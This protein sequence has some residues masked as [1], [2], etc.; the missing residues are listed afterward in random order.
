MM[1]D[2]SRALDDVA[3]WALETSEINYLTTEPDDVILSLALLRRVIGRHSCDE[4]IKVLGPL[5]TATGSLQ[6]D[7]DLRVLSAGNAFSRLGLWFARRRATLLSRLRPLKKQAPLFGA[8]V[9]GTSPDVI[10][11]V[12]GQ[13]NESSQGCCRRR[14]RALTAARHA[15][16]VTS[17]DELDCRGRVPGRVIWRVTHAAGHPRRSQPWARDGTVA[18]SCNSFEVHTRAQWGSE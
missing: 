9:I 16:G 15:P 13:F 10:W 18:A 3:R 2:R 6:C 4:P 11:L 14:H 17:R 5:I 1:R 12:L 7:L 8:L